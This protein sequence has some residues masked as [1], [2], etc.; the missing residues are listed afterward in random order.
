MWTKMRSVT[1]GCLIIGAVVLCSDTLALAQPTTQCPCQSPATGISFSLNIG[2]SGPFYVGDDVEHVPWAED[3]DEW[4]SDCIDPPEPLLQEVPPV[5]HYW[6]RHNGMFGP[7]YPGRNEN[8]GFWWYPILPSISITPDVEGIYSMTMVVADYPYACSDPPA[9]PVE[10]CAPLDCA[11]SPVT[12]SVHFY[13]A[14]TRPIDIE[15][16][17]TG[18]SGGNGDGEGEDDDDESGGPGPEGIDNPVVTLSGSGSGG[19]TVLTSPT[20]YLTVRPGPEAGPIFVTV[21]EESDPSIQTTALIQAGDCADCSDG[22]C[23]PGS[24]QVSAEGLE[25]ILSLGNGVNGRSSGAL[26]LKRPDWGDLNIT[27]EWYDRPKSAGTPG[28]WQVLPPDGPEESVEVIKELGILQQIMAPQALV[29]VVWDLAAVDEYGDLGPDM[30]V[31]Y[32]LEFYDPAYASR[33]PGDDLYTIADG[34]DPFRSWRV[35]YT[36]DE[37]SREDR[38]KFEKETDGNAEGMYEYVYDRDLAYH[39]DEFG[40]PLYTLALTK[41]F[42]GTVTTE[43]FHRAGHWQTGVFGDY[44]TVRTITLPEDGERIDTHTT[45][46]QNDPSDPE[47]VSL[48]TKRE[49]LREIVDGQSIYATT[50]WE[51]Y[52]VGDRNGF[53][54]SVRYYDGSWEWHDHDAVGR[55]ILTVRSLGDETLVVGTPPDPTL[56]RSTEYEYVPDPNDRRPRKVTERIGDGAGGEIT[57]GIT[58]YE[59]DDKTEP[60][61]TIKKIKRCFEIGNPNKYLTT[62]LRYD[63]EDVDRERP[64]SAEYPNGRKVSDSYVDGTLDD[65]ALPGEVIFTP[66]PGD[67]LLVTAIEGLATPGNLAADAVL[68][69]G[70]TTKVETYK[71]SSDRTRATQTFVCS[72]DQT[73]TYELLGMTAN[74]LDDYGHVTEDHYPDGTSQQSGWNC[75]T[76]EYAIGVDGTRTDYV[77]N[78]SNL[79]ETE[80]KLGV[81]GSGSYAAQSD[82]ITTYGRDDLGRI[83]S[84][85]E[86][87][88]GSSISLTTLKAYYFDGSLKE[89][90]DTAGLKT[91]YFYGTSASGGRLDTVVYPSGATSITEYFRDGRIKSITGTAAVH[92]H[93]AYGVLPD[94]SQWTTVYTGPLGTDSLRRARTTTDMLGRTIQ[95]A[96]YGPTRESTVPIR[97]TYNDKGQLVQTSNSMDDIPDTRYEYNLWGDVFR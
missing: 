96:R 40:R 60:G 74:V 23:A 63:E 71:D 49:V 7:V 21:S 18:T 77:Y 27:G 2:G 50:E 8:C 54:R 90:T 94:G 4:C 92:Q 31:E 41:S 20:G 75:C 86:S 32:K 67:D 91:E 19:A 53:I 47:S 36:Y 80:T 34:V 64:L 28:P 81:L 15:D 88:S 62:I 61:V 45:F 17:H 85:T 59:Y 97:N 69:A 12:A 55:K 11:D 58:E 9:P 95:T 87:G 22:G 14:T 82:I 70:K 79:L 48:L 33:E 46:P 30:K 78:A 35:E 51:Y 76:H 39:V 52:Q 44:K 29:H 38:L 93:Y 24:E 56:N 16:P 5:Y 66:G 72:D 6:K 3:I 13:A 57:V 73:V 43:E 84:T 37:P 65:A 26:F 1:L 25:V 68:V 83:E 42:G 89:T 10:D